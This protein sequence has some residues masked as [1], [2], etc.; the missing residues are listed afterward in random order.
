MADIRK[1]DGVGC[2]VRELCRRFTAPA[3][4]YLQSYILQPNVEENGC[5]MFLR[6]SNAS[7]KNKDAE[8][9]VYDRMC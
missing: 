2:P 6:D 1:C 8:G 5:D 3:E 9:E 4:E 7:L